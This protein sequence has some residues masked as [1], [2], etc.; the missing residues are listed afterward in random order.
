MAEVK[1]D[2]EHIKDYLRNAAAGL[3]RQADELDPDKPEWRGCTCPCESDE[4]PHNGRNCA[5]HGCFLSGDGSCEEL[6]PAH[7]C[8]DC[9]NLDAPWPSDTHVEDVWEDLVNR[10]DH[11]TKDERG[12]MV[13]L[14]LDDLAA[15]IRAERQKGIDQSEFDDQPRPFH[16]DLR[17]LEEEPI[18]VRCADCPAR[19]ANGG[20]GHCDEGQGC[21][22]EG[23]GS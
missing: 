5:Q 1:S 18:P 20:C 6:P 23:A 12:D 3:R 17:D 8:K 21:L 13:L 14:S 19:Y 11:L 4:G 7:R 2:A 10:N 22:E 15:I 16:P 9:P